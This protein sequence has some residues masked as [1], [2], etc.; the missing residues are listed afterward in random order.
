MK[1][2]LKMISLITTSVLLAAAFAA[3]SGGSAPASSVASSAPADSQAAESTAPAG[4]GALD[5][6]APVSAPLADAE[7]TLVAGTPV[8][9]DSVNHYIVYKA[10]QLMEEKSGGRVTMSV[11]EGGQLGA[12][13]EIMEGMQAGTI[14]F[15]ITISATFT[16]FAPRTGVFDLPNV[17][18]SLEVARKV[19]DSGIVDDVAPDYEAAGFKMFG[20][21]D[22]GFRQTTTNK[23]ITTLADFKGLK[24]RTMQTPYHL[25]YWNAVGASPTPM[26]FG[27]LYIGLQQGAVDAQENPYDL[28]VANKLYEPQK[29]ITETNHVLHALTMLMSKAKYDSLPDDIKTIVEESVKEALQYGRAV[30]DERLE[31]RK[32]IVADYGCI[33]NE[34]SPELRQEILTAIEPVY[35]Q[36]RNEIGADLV[37]KLIAAS[38]EAENS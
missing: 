7:F 36:M 28:I 11:F 14:D 23:P 20:F 5:Q 30:A 31:S 9:E 15:Y 22:A 1:N 12:D 26:D 32:K 33:I 8:A 3:C 18:S 10:K 6:A 2:V 27:E 34:M 17:F 13:R 21:S 37:D 35:D 24:I 4:G 19:L 16:P 29:Y 38:A 25:A